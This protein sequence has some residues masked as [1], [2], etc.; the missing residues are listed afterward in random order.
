[1]SKIGL[2]TLYRRNYNMGGLLQAY[3]LVEKCRQINPCTEQISFDYK[4]YY[5]KNMVTTSKIKDIL[6]L[7][8][9][10][11]KN[12]RFI[13]RYLNFWKFESRIPHSTKRYIRIS[14]TNY[15]CIIVG[16]DQVWGEWLPKKALFQF[17]LADEKIQGKL[18]SYAASIGSDI[19]SE[20]QKNL[21]KKYLSR[22]ETI[23]LRE[24][25]A[26]KQMIDLLPEKEIKV[27]LDPTLLLT[28]D[29]WSK[30]AKKAKCPQRYIFCYFLGKDR[31]YRDKATTFAQKLR[32]PIVTMPYT[33][34]HTIEKYEDEF[35]DVC[36]YSS[37]PSEF[38][39]LVKNAEL[40]LTDSFHATVFSIQFHKPFYSLARV[41]LET[42]SSNSRITDLLKC[43]SLSKQ[44]IDIATL[45]EIDSIPAI[46]YSDFDSKIV[47]YRREAEAYLKLICK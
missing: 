41:N 23:S 32:L 7:L 36:D 13:K 47:D 6:F 17:L 5:G 16:S 45:K 25:S 2:L 3:A 37:G 20:Y 40:V 4:Q 35:G 19:F 34:D 24:E 1:M 12:P 27:H 8:K 14:D 30:I 18:H 33:K 38:I 43:F 46:D 15:D 42:T 39:Y 11:A 10:S 28:A 44:Y 9:K 22:F 21:F 26:Q 29:D 31:Q